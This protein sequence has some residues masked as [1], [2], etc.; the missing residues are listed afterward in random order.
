MQQ[1]LR[2]KWR[3]LEVLQRLNRKKGD[4]KTP[5]DR[6]NASDSHSVSGSTTYYAKSNATR[7]RDA[8][9]DDAKSQHTR[10][11]KQQTT[12]RDSPAQT[13]E[14][15]GS[16][17]ASR[18]PADKVPEFEVSLANAA[19]LHDF[20]TTCNVMKRLYD[21]HK[22][23]QGGE[24]EEASRARI[25]AIRDFVKESSESGKD[26]REKALRID[27]ILAT[28]PTK[29]NKVAFMLTSTKAHLSRKL[30]E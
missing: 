30:S 20:V 13:A 18:V 12:V 7:P 16:P 9:R 28:R 23:I 2:F 8:S 26:F 6:D 1:D 11:R 15:Q 5:R 24:D 19:E 4:R 10:F 22:K 27:G 25:Q 3:E 21:C 14:D 29:A 17:G